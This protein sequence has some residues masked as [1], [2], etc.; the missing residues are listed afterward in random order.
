MR[1]PLRPNPTLPIDQTFMQFRSQQQDFLNRLASSR[2][3]PRLP[4]PLPFHPFLSSPPVS[5]GGKQFGSHTNSQ[6]GGDGPNNSLDLGSR[7][8]SSPPNPALHHHHHLHQHHN[9]A[10]ARMSGTYDNPHSPNDDSESEEAK[11]RRSRTNFSQWQLEELERVFQSC[12][13]PDVFMR[14][15][16]ALKLDL[17]ESR[18][19]VWFQNRR[20]KFRKK[21]NTKKGPGRPAHNAHPQTCSGEPISAEELHKKE[22]ER[23]DRKL[24]KQL[25]K[26]QKKMSAKGVHVELEALRRDYEI[27]KAGGKS[28]M[29]FDISTMDASSNCGDIDVVGGEGMEEDEEEEE[30]NLEDRHSE[31]KPK[32]SP[33][34]IESLLSSSVAA[35]AAVQAAVHAANHKKSS[36]SNSSNNSS[37]HHLQAEGSDDDSRPCSPISSSSIP[38]VKSVSNLGLGQLEAVTTPLWHPAT[39]LSSLFSSGTFHHLNPLISGALCHNPNSP[40]SAGSFNFA[41]KILQRH[42]ELQQQQLQQQKQLGQ[43]FSGEDEED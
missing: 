11:R 13:Y 17:K 27:Q 42:Q 6:S 19:S 34:S 30:D 40:N 33:F 22:I 32:V 41:A 23:R 7:G 5:G 14:E 36:N 3:L 37:H 8:S 9:N 4:L 15:A 2:N 1:L 16:L 10:G 21:E 12:H 39:T 38:I 25:E 18:I 43:R 26:Q 24:L 35:A 28:T 31:T 29:D 20:A